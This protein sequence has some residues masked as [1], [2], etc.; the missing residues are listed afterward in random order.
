MGRLTTNVSAALRRLRAWQLVAAARLRRR[1]FFCAALAGNSD[2]NVCV[3]S[4]LTVSCNCHDVDGS[5]RIGHLG[6]QSL[7][8]IFA[9]PMAQRFRQEL[10][11]GRLPTPQCARCSDLR[12][13]PKDKAE[14]LVDRYHLP[15]FLMVENTSRCNLQCTSCPRPQIRRLRKKHSMSLDDVR[16]VAE[17][18]RDAGIASVA[19][20]NFG[21]PFLSK[22]IRQEL[23]ILREENP[24]LRINTST[25]AMAIDCDEKREAALLLDR[26]QISLDG[27]DQEMVAKYQ[28]GMDFARA[29]RNM[30]SLVEYRD[31]R[32]LSAPVIVWKYLLFWWNDRERHLETAIELGRQAGVDE[33]FFEKTVSPFYGIS[34]RYRL[35]LLNSISEKSAWGIGVKL[36][37]HVAP[38]EVEPPLANLSVK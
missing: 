14:R 36:R 23:E 15:T 35:G 16:R 5:G 22:N 6:R 19:Y 37:E 26:I 11:R 3:N 9:G 20:L 29:Y 28:R 10:A 25:N 21:E 12:S 13:V 18:V 34:W 27:I 24:G 30:K 17:Q 38:C 2:I 33:M 8:A 1:A 4:D 7:A 32:G 31:A